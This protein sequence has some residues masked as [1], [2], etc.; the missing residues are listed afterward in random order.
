MIKKL[1]TLSLT[2]M[3]MTTVM[4]QSQSKVFRN[5]INDKSDSTKPCFNRGGLVETTVL[6]EDFSKFTAGS[7]SVP[8]ALRL[9]NASGDISDEYF[10]TPGW[11][12]SEIYQAGG[13][14]YIGFSEEYNESGII[15]T[16]SVNTQGAVHIKCRVRCESPEGEV[17]GYN[18]F[19]DYGEFIDT[20]V[21]F[22]KATD[23]WTDISW[24]TT[25]GTENSH[26]WIFSYGK[27]IFIDDIEIVS[28]SLPAP[29]LLEETDITGNAFTANWEEI[30]DVD[31]YIFRLLAE[32]TAIQDET[33]YYT[34]TDFSNVVSEGTTS[35][36]EVVDSWEMM[37]NGWHIYM[38]IL[39]DGAIGVTGKYYYN[40]QYGTITSPVSDFSSDNGNITISFKAYGNINDELEVSLFTPAYGYYDIADYKYVRIGNDGWNEYSVSLRKGMEES[41]IEITYFGAGDVFFDDIKLYQTITEGETK[42]FILESSEIQATSHRV[43]VDDAHINDILYYQVAATKFVYSQNGDKIIGSIDSGFSDTR[44]SPTNTTGVE[45][46]YAQQKAVAYFHNGLLNISNPDNETVFVY[47]INGSCL[48]QSMTDGTADIILPK[49]VYIVKVGDKTAKII[50]N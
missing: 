29:A 17:I 10:S 34:N 18:I 3:F 24:F 4:A 49:G 14:A 47:S 6:S 5:P 16:P 15:I 48:Y 20:N 23:E 33:F 13:C 37:I 40:E 7:E 30:E 27:N 38:P 1:V 21:D 39:I 26:I 19:D 50:N 35:S 9:D 45:S 32:H 46:I 31:A 43:T 12:G 2:I 42:T 25:A 28:Y 11:K 36:P 8:D 41:Y 44:M 22:F